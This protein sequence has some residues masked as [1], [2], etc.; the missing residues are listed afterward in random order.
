VKA[1]EPPFQSQIFQLHLGPKQERRSKP[2]GT[3][4]RSNFH[5]RW[6]QI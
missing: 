1:A 2:S 4:C 6:Y 3:H 5:R